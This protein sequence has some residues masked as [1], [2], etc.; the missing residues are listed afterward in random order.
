MLRRLL[1]HPLTKNLA[2]DDPRTTELRR[3]I[4]QSKPFLCKIYA[5]WYQMLAGSLPADGGPVLE[6]GSGAGFLERYVPRLVKS[7]VFPCCGANLVLDGQRLPFADG[8]LSAI[9][10]SDVLHHLPSVRSFLRD[11]ARC[12]R[13][14]GVVS[15]IEPWVSPWSGWVFSHFHHEGIAPQAET[16]E[17]PT[18]GPLSS[19]NLALPWIVFNRDR[20]V[21]EREFPQWHVETVRPFMPFRYFL[22]GGISTRNLLPGWSYGLW[23]TFEEFFSLRMPRWAMFAHIVLRLQY[24]D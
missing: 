16:W 12:V 11:A 9:V 2:L 21:F 7:D 13:E 10:M 6:L 1:A 22:S 20:N 4:L 17:F 18:A 24:T 14:G 8:S 15:M 23:K 19:A 3:V 5:E